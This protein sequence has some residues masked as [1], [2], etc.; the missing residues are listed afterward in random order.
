[1]FKM[2]C[3]FEMSHA[4]SE[5]TCAE[6]MQPLT[7]SEEKTMCDLTSFTF[8]LCSCP[9][10]SHNFSLKGYKGLGVNERNISSH[11]IALTQLFHC[12]TE[13]SRA[14]DLIQQKAFMCHRAEEHNGT[15]GAMSYV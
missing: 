9:G 6:N 13:L 11:E 1:M 10:P 14:V 7:V 8:L 15:A 5:G 12:H 4:T 3:Q 2:G